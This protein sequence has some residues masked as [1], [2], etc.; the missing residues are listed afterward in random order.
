MAVTKNKSRSISLEE[1]SH[2]DHYSHQSDRQLTAAEREVYEEHVNSVFDR[3]RKLRKRLENERKHS[4]DEI[5]TGI[6]KSEIVVL[7]KKGLVKLFKHYHNTS[8]GF[9]NFLV[10]TNTEESRR[11]Q[12]AQVVITSPEQKVE[13]ILQEIETI[14]DQQDMDTNFS[15]DL[16]SKVPH[17]FKDKVSLTGTAWF[18]SKRSRS[19]KSSTSK[20]T[21]SVLLEQKVKK[22]S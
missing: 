9:L 13:N 8:E 5:T 4:H 15:P 6:D 17:D 2:S 3:L 18:V 22:G 11:E 21:T 16:E 12:A 7:L 1:S 10:R 19:S 14:I 20:S